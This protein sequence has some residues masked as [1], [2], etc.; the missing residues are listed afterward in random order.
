MWVTF[1]RPHTGGVSLVRHARNF[2]VVIFAALLT[3]VV[4][5]ATVFAADAKWE[6]GDLIY[7]DRTYKSAGVASAHVAEQIGIPA[8]ADYYENIDE[9]VTPNISR[10][11]YFPE[12]TNK[13]DAT[14]AQYVEASLEGGGTEA[15]TYTNIRGPTAV[16]VD[17]ASFE[18]GGTAEQTSCA[19]DGVGFI[20]C[21][22]MMLLAEAMD[23]MFNVLKSLL[24]VAP[25]TGGTH[26]GLYEAWK[27]MLALANLC[28]VAG[29]L[30]VIYSYVTGQG[31]GNY[32]LRKIIPRIIIA[33]VLINA[34]YHI[35]AIAVDASNIFGANLQDVFN[36]MRSELATNSETR[37]DAT[38]WGI[39]TTFILS[40]GTIGGGTA[41]YFGLGAFAGAALHLLTPI[42]V[43]CAIAIFVALVV[44][45]LRQALITV[46]IV[47]APLAF[48]AFILPSTQKYFDKW[49]DLFMTMLIMYPMFSVLFGGAQLAAHIIA[50][51][52]TS[53]L[54]LLFAMFIQVAPLVLTPFLIKFSGSLLGRIAGMVNNP[55]KGLGD[56]INNRS[57]AKR[58]L[59]L[60]QNVANGRRGTGLARKLM[61]GK[62]HDEEELK[63]AQARRKRKREATQRGRDLAVSAMYED[64]MGEAVT[65]D[66]KA[67]FDARKLQD[68]S[69][70]Q[71]DAA[72]H[73][74]S[75]LQA[76]ARAGQVS[77]L[78][79]EL[80][81]HRGAELRTEGNAALAG[82][83]HDMHDL[84]VDGMIAER[85]EAMAKAQ[86]NSEFSKM[87]DSSGKEGDAK[88]AAEA[89]QREAGGVNPSGALRVA[90]KASADRIQTDADDVK[91]VLTA[92]DVQAGDSA[93]AAKRLE[94]AIDAGDM[95]SMRA[96]TDMLAAG[97]DHGVNTLRQV[98]T[99]KSDQILAMDDLDV[100]KHHINGNG[101]LNQSAEDIG[102]WSRET[103]RSVSLADVTNGDFTVRVGDRIDT[104][105]NWKSLSPETFAGMK[106]TSQLL[107]LGYKLDANGKAVKPDNWVPNVSPE[108]ARTVM[109]TPTLKGKIKDAVRPVLQEIASQA[110]DGPRPIPP[111]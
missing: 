75:G 29:F 89:L 57:K 26:T 61:D 27:Y 12:N 23:K 42:L 36:G 58:Q 92:S 14:N 65:N 105:N 53:I 11:L 17:Q 76:K 86:H 13:E 4:F 7:D 79:H 46:L 91:A 64:M 15:T 102:S 39:L 81:T 66:N 45:A 49:K 106:K 48:A 104:K 100:Y 18:S 97:S 19:I 54:T 2:L 94:D 85:R 28:F 107:A 84:G 74:R 93:A 87:L 55:A 101:S 31:V 69:Q 62:A 21:P 24:H 109:D 111:A 40:A 67:L 41:L 99:R 10:I 37:T 108:L 56:R 16:A 83:A 73:A 95:I 44:L 60:E 9:E 1:S 103:S 50:Q 82:V 38:T 47:V 6:G 25:L 80:E 52:A 3:T 59:A 98:L 22:I 68:G 72:R 32:D 5:S 34:S 43:A 71:L 63:R 35:C 51:N 70:E 96:Y 77:A 110:P 78:M 20:I 90:A 33:A 30:V 8:G 88:A